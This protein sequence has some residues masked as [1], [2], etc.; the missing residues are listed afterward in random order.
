M[1]K[2]YGRK[3]DQGDHSPDDEDDEIPRGERPEYP[4]PVGYQPLGLAAA[5]VGEA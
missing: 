3:E 2:N 4:R 1:R 5:V